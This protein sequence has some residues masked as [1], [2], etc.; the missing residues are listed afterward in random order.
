V[1]DLFLAVVDLARFHKV[2][3]ESALRQANARFK[4]RFNFIEEKARLSG[5]KVSDLSLK[6]MLDYWEE[7]KSE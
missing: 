1:G 6:E 3:A 5:R 2:E 7:A 4:K